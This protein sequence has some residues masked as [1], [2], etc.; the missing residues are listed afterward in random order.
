MS[1]SVNIPEIHALRERVEQVFGQPLATHNA[2]LALV[3]AID[4]ALREHLS[5]STL[6]RLWKYSTRGA[7]AVSMRTLDV[8]ARYAGTD[9]WKQFCQSVKDSS[10]VE[11]EEFCG[12]SI[13]TTRLQPG[14][15]LRLGWLPDRL[16]GVVYLGQNRFV[17]EESLNSSLQPGDSFEC[18]QIQVGRPLY[19]DRFRRAGSTAEARYVAGERNGLT[20]VCIQ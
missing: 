18:L 19:L 4:T 10:P 11:S 12:E 3:D 14:T 1:V 13:I 15:R 6:E 20:S 17:V 2:F 9:S 7:D 5:E 8:L 16:I